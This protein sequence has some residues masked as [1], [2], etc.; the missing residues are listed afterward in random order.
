MKVPILIAGVVCLLLIG[1][2]PA[3]AQ[4]KAAPMSVEKITEMFAA[5]DAN[6]NGL[7]EREEWLL[8][9]PKERRPHAEPMW[10][11]IS[12]DGRAVTRER[13]IEVYTTPVSGQ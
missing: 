4:R 5:V 2:G 9:L 3:S 1:T 10:L 11:R 7:L 12:T 6:N 13:L 8:T